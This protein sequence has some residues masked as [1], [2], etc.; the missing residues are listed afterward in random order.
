MKLSRH[1]KKWYERLISLKG[2]PRDL[3]FG[4]AIGVFIGV[5]PTIP[6][7]TLL[8]VLLCFMLKKNL[9]AAYLGS[10]MISNPLTIPFLYMTQYRLGKYLLGNGYPRCMVK[11][12]S[13]LHLIQRGWDVVLPLLAGGVIMAPFFAVPTYFIARKILRTVRKNRHEYGEEHT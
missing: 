4:L 6:F 13:L 2:R 1:A 5:T 3:A 8:I 9:T 10:W 7:H 11:E 12:Y